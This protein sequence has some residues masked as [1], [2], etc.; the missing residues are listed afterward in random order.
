MGNIL[1]NPK[2]QQK[3]LQGVWIQPD[4]KRYYTYSSLA[5]NVLGFVTA[6]NQ[7]GVGLEAKYNDALEGTSGLTVTA[8]N[9]AG[10][11]LLFGSGERPRSVL[12]H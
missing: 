10:T 12:N 5:S 4:S 1:P 8:K 11:P 2:E 9:A 6:E 7:G 3:K